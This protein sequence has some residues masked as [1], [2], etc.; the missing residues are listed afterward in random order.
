MLKRILCIL[1]FYDTEPTEIYQGLIWAIIFPAVY[2][3]EHGGNTWIVVL[4]VLIGLSSIKA[5]CQCQLLFRKNMA[6]AVFIM[7]L[8][9]LFM[10]F[11][12]GMLLK[13]PSHWMW[14]LVSINAFFNLIAITNHYVKNGDL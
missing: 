2:L 7:S 5:A 8:L 12:C 9:S 14:I 13:S 4:S 1:S 6:L 3:A 11:N 10:F